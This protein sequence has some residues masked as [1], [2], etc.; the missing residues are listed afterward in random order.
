MAQLIKSLPAM[1][2]T[3]VRSLGGEDPLEEE[4]ATTPV[5]LPGKFCGQT[6]GHKESDTTELLNFH[7]LS[8]W[9]CERICVFVG[10]GA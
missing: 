7:F 3:Q 10:T 4:M 1:R 9:G 2:E 6:W 8:L 5:L